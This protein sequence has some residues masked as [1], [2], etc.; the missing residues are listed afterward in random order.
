MPAANVT[1]VIDQGEDFTTQIIWTDDQGQAHVL[2]AP[3]RLDIKGAGNQPV[4]SLTTPD[5]PI[6]DGT[7]PEISYSS[8]IGMIQLHIPK[9][10]TEALP[11]G[12]YQYDMFVTVDDNDA[13]AGTQQFRLLVGQVVVN[14]RITVM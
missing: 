9:E 8:E 14:Q 11:A 6:P 13:Y 2:A 1:L 3:M 4:L 12:M 10:Q 7:I 5:T